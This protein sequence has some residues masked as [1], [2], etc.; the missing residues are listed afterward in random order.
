MSRTSDRRL[1]ALQA[2]ADRPG[3]EAEGVLAREI[4]DRLK[5]KPEE[6]IGEY[7]KFLRGQISL[8]EFLN[9]IK[10]PPLTVEEQAVVEMR[11]AQRVWRENRKRR[12]AEDYQKRLKKLAVIES[13]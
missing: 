7:Q 2:L 13:Q 9:S 11:E 8:N 12:E 3:T 4:L 10:H 1:A 5:N 6:E